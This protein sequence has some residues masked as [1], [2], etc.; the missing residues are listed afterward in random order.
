MKNIVEMPVQTS[1]QPVIALETMRGQVPLYQAPVA[2]F[3]GLIAAFLAE[4]GTLDVASLDPGGCIVKFFQ[5]GISVGQPVTMSII[6]TGTPVVFAGVGPTLLAPQTFGETPPL[7]TVTT[8]TVI[9]APPTFTPTI[10]DMTGAW[11]STALWLPKGARMVMTA[12]IANQSIRFGI[13]IQAI[14]ASQTEA[15]G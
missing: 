11:D 8:G 15:D 4:F 1:I 13:A 7:T 2:M 14:E 3:G 12:L 9:G 5:Q 6:T 10:L